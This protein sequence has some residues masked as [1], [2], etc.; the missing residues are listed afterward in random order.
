MVIRRLVVQRFVGLLR[1][2]AHAF[3]GV[4]CLAVVG[5]EGCSINGDMLGIEMQAS[6][7]EAHGGR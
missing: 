2:Q 5:G 3:Y 7:W 1:P 4:R 6:T